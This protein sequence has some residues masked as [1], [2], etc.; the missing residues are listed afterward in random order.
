[1]IFLWLMNNYN[2]VGLNNVLVKLT[3]LHELLEYGPVNQLLKKYKFAKK[4]GNN[5]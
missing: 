4:Q 3:L 1:M 2:M 5:I